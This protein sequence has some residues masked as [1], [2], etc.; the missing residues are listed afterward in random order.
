MKQRPSL[1]ILQADKT[2]KQN[3]VYF[4]NMSKNYFLYIC[5]IIINET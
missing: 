3:L 2:S 1:K 4:M 5:L